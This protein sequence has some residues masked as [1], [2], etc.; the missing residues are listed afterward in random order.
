MFKVENEE[1]LGNVKNNLFNSKSFDDF[2]DQIV[3]ICQEKTSLILDTVIQDSNKHNRNINLRWNVIRGYEK[4]LERVIVYNEDITERKDA[5]KII[6]NSQEKI[7][8]LIDTVDGIVWECNPETFEF[9]FVSKKVEEILG[10]SAEEWLSS[11][12][13]WSDHIY[14]EDKESIIDFCQFKS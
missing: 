1:D 12:T 2:V 5:D 13:F 3:A 10:Y 8:S 11:P 4:T 6:R 7:Q 14:V 9:T